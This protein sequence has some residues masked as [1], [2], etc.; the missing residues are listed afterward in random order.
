MTGESRKSGNV[1]S[2]HV[3]GRVGETDDDI[4]HGGFR[5]LGQL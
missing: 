1:K 5:K 4:G 2:C 3:G